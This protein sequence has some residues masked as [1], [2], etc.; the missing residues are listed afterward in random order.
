[1]QD[2]TIKIIREKEKLPE[3]NNR[4]F[5]HSSTLFEIL[6]DVP[7]VVPFM[8]TANDSEGKVVA[9]LLAV[10]RKN[11]FII[12]SIIRHGHIF[13]E[14]V[15]ADECDKN[16]VFRMMLDAATAEFKK[17]YCIYIEISGISAKMFGYGSLRAAGYFPI[18]WMEIHNSLH[19]KSPAQRLLPIRRKRILKAAAAG[20]KTHLV[21]NDETFRRF[22]S[23]L[24]HFYT[25]RLHRYSPNKQEVYAIGTSSYGKMYVTKYKD[26]IIG[27][28]V[29]IISDGDA[30]L[31]H[32][33]SKRKTFSTLFPTSQ[34]IWHALEDAHQN[35]IRHF[36]F[37]DVGIPVGKSHLRDFILR[38]GGRP[39][40]SYRW[41][42]CSI[43]GVNKILS[44]IF[45]S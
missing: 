44:K 45:T 41:F 34:M 10:I 27:G 38:F 6:N 11:T 31:W 28:C 2:I 26:R 20:V 13:G 9:H 19:S 3:I 25:S 5:F 32:M 16:R 39:E 22:F 21:K 8:V 4:N 29:C 1:M 18:R 40:S 30:Y 33:A 24:K 35:G 15:Y 37:M 43:I 12:P 17:H 36:N 7:R 23:M 42:N 14:G